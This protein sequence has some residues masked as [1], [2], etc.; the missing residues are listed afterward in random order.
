MR[1]YEN[2]KDGYISITDFI[3][4][5]AKVIV[6]VRQSTEVMVILKEK[7]NLRLM[8]GSRMQ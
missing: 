2:R 3:G 5:T 8:K 4:L 6:R 1:R 7:Q